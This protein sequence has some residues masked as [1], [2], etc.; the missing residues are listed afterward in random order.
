MEGNEIEMRIFEYREKI[1]E[2][3]KEKNEFSIK[4]K[5][6][7][8]EML[9]LAEERIKEKGFEEGTYFRF[10]QDN[11]TY[12]G[13]ITSIY[14]KYCMQIMYY[15]IELF[16]PNRIDEQMIFRIDNHSCVV[17]PSEVESL[18]LITPEE[19]NEFL[20]KCIEENKA[21]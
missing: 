14:A 18:V 17:C 4:A 16:M 7:E 20:G 8:D 12:I 1:Q 13:R 9:K 3:Q 10:N 6:L 11:V 5:N 21:K 19:Y 15:G 2:L